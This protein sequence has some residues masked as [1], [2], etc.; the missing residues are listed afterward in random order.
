MSARSRTHAPVPADV[1][2]DDPAD[3]LAADH[4]PAPSAPAASAPQTPHTARHAHPTS[5]TRHLGPV[6]IP[7]L[8]DFHV[9]PRVVVISLL[10]IPI[11]AVAAVVAAGLLKLIALITNLSFQGRFGFGSSAP[12]DTA[13]RWLLLMMPVVGGLVIGLM[14]R[15]GSEKIRGHGMP[16][17]IESILV[18]GSRVQPRVAALKPASA[19]ISIGTGGPFGAEGPII[20]TGGAV[21][22][23]IAQFLRVTTDE[24]KALLVAGSAAGMAATFNAPLASILLAVELLLFEWRPRSYLPVAVAAVTA[25]LVRG[26]L[27]GT[28]PLFGGAHVP[29]HIAFSAYGLCIVAGAAAGLLALGATALV[30]F[31][32]DLFSRLRIHWMWWPAIGGAIIG[33]GGLVE[34]RTLGVGYDVIDA[35]LTGHATV[36]L[37]VGVLVVKTLI[38]GLSLGSGTSGG[39]LA[40]MFMV[41]GA[42]GAA[43]ALVFPHVSPG[44]WALVSLAGV[45]GGVMRS[46]LTGIVFC[47]ELTHEI[48]AMIPMVITASAA[49]LLSVILLKRSVLTEKLARRGLHLTREYSVDPLEVHLVRQ[50]ETPVAVT[51][52]ADQPAGEITALL[53]AAHDGGDADRLLAQRLYPVLD[54]DGGL[55]GVVTRGALVHADPADATPLGELACA[56]VVAHPD[57]TLRA[58][59]NRMAHRE[60]TRLLVVTRGERPEVEGIISL[61]DLL[62]ARR[63]DHH[64][65]HHAERILTLRPRGTIRVPSTTIAKGKKISA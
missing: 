11:G 58:L 56:P 31:S 17:A 37:I 62:T 27:L 41:G 24:R 61:R 34:P 12:A 39:V 15:Y 33:V 19:A 55:A 64:E 26:P 22:S 3:A 63:I 30:Y 16:E 32:E 8:G 50:L 18:G 28:D 14:A 13:H 60:V 4:P 6:K 36:G 5:P 44:F 53:R 59:A 38:W 65:E 2:A 47:L 51:F 48:N 49:Y 1:P 23:L 43:E 7:H 54:A 52:R 45:L 35:L 40:P 9:P 29:A 21:G 20:M 10:A 57:E 42:L 46:P 25:T